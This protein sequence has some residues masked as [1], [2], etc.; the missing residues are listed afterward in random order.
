MFQESK[1]EAKDFYDLTSK[2]MWHHLSCILQVQS[3]FSMGGPHKCMHARGANLWGTLLILPHH[4]W[5]RCHL[6]EE[7]IK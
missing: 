7:S 4:T 2:V 6:C 5:D 3:Q 1:A